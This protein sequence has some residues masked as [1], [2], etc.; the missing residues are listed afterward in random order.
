MDPNE[1]FSHGDKGRQCHDSS[2]WENVNVDGELKTLWIVSEGSGMV[3]N[4]FDFTDVKTTKKFPGEPLSSTPPQNGIYA[5]SNAL[6]EDKRFLFQF[7]E[8]NK[9]DIYVYD[10]SNV[11]QPSY[12]NRF[13]YS[14]EDTSNAM[15]HNGHIRGGYLHVAYYEAGLRTFD[16]SNPYE[17]F[18]VGKI[19]TYRDPQ[20]TGTYDSDRPIQGNYRGAWNSYVGLS[21]GNILVTDMFSGLFIVKANS[22]YPEPNAPTLSAVRNANNDVTLTWNAVPNARAY[23]V[24]RRIGGQPFAFVVIAEFLTTTSYFDNSVR[25]TNASYKVKAVNGEGTGVSATV[26]SAVLTASPTKAPTNQPTPRP[27]PLPTPNPTSPPSR[28]PTPQPS[29]NPTSIQD[30]LPIP[31]PATSAPTRDVLYSGAFG[32]LRNN[33][34][35]STQCFPPVFDK[36]RAVN[37]CQVQGETLECDR[38]GCSLA[39]SFVEATAIC[40]NKGMRLCSTQ[41]LESDVCCSK[42]CNFDGRVGWTTDICAPQTPAPT[43]PPPTPRPTPQPTGGTD[44]LPGTPYPTFEATGSLQ[45]MAEPL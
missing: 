44:E 45:S 16:I 30:D 15:P 28:T 17:I 33:D 22:P 3:E 4:I 10:I 12:I 21:S 20:Q 23:S 38:S 19:E 7:D 37:C 27:S 35:Q 41:E 40:E 2:L 43:S 24:E 26:E 32:C 36:Q 6:S 9:G 42:G 34:P 39:S 8:N 5:H 31:V 29:P 14:E 1:I 18:E 13:Q 11:T 25:D